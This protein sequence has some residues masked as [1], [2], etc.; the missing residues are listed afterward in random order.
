M[1]SAAIAD[2][3]RVATMGD[4]DNNLAKLNLPERQVPIMV[5]LDDAARQDLPLCWSGWPCR[6][7]TG[8]CGWARSRG[9][10]WPA[11]RP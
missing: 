8:R 3:L 5:R 10:N 1:T 7:R 4:Y 6:A 2:T 9:W 11:A